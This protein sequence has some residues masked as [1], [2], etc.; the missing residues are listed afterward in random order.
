MG[1][2]RRYWGEA[3]LAVA[4]AGLTVLFAR[5]VLLVGVGGVAGW[6][7]ARQYDFVRTV[8]DVA[9]DLSVVQ[10]PENEVVAVDDETQVTLT[11]ELPCT[12]P[13]SLAVRANPPPGVEVVG[14]EEPTAVVSPG[15]ETA[16]TAFEVRCPLA[17]AFEFGPATVT[18]TDAGGRFRTTFVAE[19][20][21]TL[22]VEARGPRNLHVGTGGEARDSTF[23]RNDSDERGPG[24]DLAEIRAY[25][26][27]D[28]VREI[29]WNV[30]ARLGEPHVR[31]YE[32][33][34]ERRIALLLDR[35][36]S[37]AAGPDGETKFDYARQVALSIVSHAR[38]R[39][40]PVALYEVGEGGLL[41]RH[42][43]TATE[44][45][46]VR[47]ERRLRAVEPERGR[48]PERDPARSVGEASAPDAADELE[49]SASPAVARERTH[50]L[51]GDDSAFADRLRP[52][53]AAADPY[54]QRIT[55][56]P[57]YGVARVHLERLRGMVTAVV[58]TDDTRRVET[59]E[60]VKMARR[61]DDSV[62]TFL[63]PTVLFDR[64]GGADL[65]T[66]Y[67]RYADFE[68]FRRGLA[69]I[70]RVTAFEVGPGDRLE[71]L[72]AANEARKQA[73]TGD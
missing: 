39:G 44:E 30:T 16:T 72:L 23:G 49:R 47:L 22:T 11:V 54:A 55:D 42:R 48:E 10:S 32:T 41:A 45:G 1:V 24:I 17:G 27:G 5:P 12:A 8:G 67:E 57:L 25:V 69:S 62:L 2:T 58:L 68:E 46:Y 37:M 66:A 28:R 34:T 7:L 21:A 50:R 38:E 18:A 36:A 29:D 63:T 6:L 73:S 65:E 61:N 51:G 9:T 60:V 4:L 70:D 31:E 56:D 35:R 3:G 59:R 20:E 43:P 40:D 71:A 53:F 64:D 14:D 19:S 15:E 26:P 13:V 52:F 33:E